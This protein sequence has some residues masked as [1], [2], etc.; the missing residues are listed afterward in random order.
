MATAT[1]TSKGQITLPR[2]IRQALG[3]EPGDRVSFVVREDGTV[4]VEAATTDLLD[5]R[6]SLKPRRKG[7]SIE[8]MNAAVR[9]MGKRA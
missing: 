5:L 4:V 9:R 8:E 1:I 7:V 3:V 2:D 6:G